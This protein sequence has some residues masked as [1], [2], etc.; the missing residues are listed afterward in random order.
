MGT[1]T[2]GSQTAGSS[3]WDVW[4][5]Y[6]NIS[7]LASGSWST[8]T[9]DTYIDGIRIFCGTTNG[10]SGNPGGLQL[11][12][13]GLYTSGGALLVT[14]PNLTINGT[15]QWYG[16]GTSSLYHIA[17]NTQIGGAIHTGGGQGLM[18]WGVNGGQGSYGINTS[19]TS[20]QGGWTNTTSKSGW[21]N[22]GWYA[23][24]FPAASISNLSASGA[25]EGQS[26][27]IYG[28]SFSAGINSVD[29]NGTGASYT[30]VNDTQIVATVPN[31]A[32]SGP[33]H[34]N[35]N[36]G[37]ATSGT[38]YVDPNIT[39]ISPTSGNPGDGVTINGSG[40]LGV[41][42]VNFY[43]G[44]GAS[45][46]IGSDNQI[47]ATVPSG[48]TTGAI[49]AYG[50]NSA[51]SSS[52]FT[53]LTSITSFT[54]TAGGVGTA[55]TISGTGF[56]GASA[57]KFNGTSASFTVTN[58]TTISTSVPNGA[59]TGPIS[60]TGTGGTATSA[61]SFTVAPGWYHEG[62]VITRLKGMW[63]KS[64]GTLHSIQGAWYKSGGT[65]H[66]LK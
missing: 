34:V 6:S 55:V 8:T 32:T 57:V 16:Q 27:T 35:T 37:T 60:V 1:K 61:Q 17:P 38:F 41:T 33:I 3:N 15:V 31:G 23:T 54:P 42:T 51:S 22:L 52:T 39:S 65:L 10:S 29:F 58:D 45:Y 5:N 44:V 20:L 43:N 64:G 18:I 48:A 13:L 4:F 26:I 62:G 66:P 7:A 14:T 11:A 53:V 50:G 24:Y 40:F 56:T 36:A 59:T 30:Y 21:G 19:V 12:Q 9:E 63:Y 2:I 25:T 47:S 28:Q 46:T 49:T